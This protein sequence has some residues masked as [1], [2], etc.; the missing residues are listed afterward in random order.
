MPG[1]P[2]T[3]GR[4]ALAL[5]RPFVLPSVYG[6]GVGTRDYRPFAAQWLACALPC[7]RFAGTLAGDRRTARGRCGSLL[8]HRRWTC[9]TYSLPVSRRTTVGREQL[10]IAHEKH[11]RP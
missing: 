3:P 4:R 8:L 9:T 7:R 2:T 11:C 10:A 1:S 6:N 5:T